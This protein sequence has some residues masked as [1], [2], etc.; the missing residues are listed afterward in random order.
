MQKTKFKDH[1][2][3]NSGKLRGA[4]ASILTNPFCGKALKESPN[5][6]EFADHMICNIYH[7]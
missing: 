7:A 6:M 1:E 5:S 2:E 3:L 4:T